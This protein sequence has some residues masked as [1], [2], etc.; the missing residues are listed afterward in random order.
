MEQIKKG[1]FELFKETFYFSED[2]KE[3]KDEELS[4]WIKEKQFIF[5]KREIEWDQK[6]LIPSKRGEH[7]ITFERNIGSEKIVQEKYKKICGTAVGP[8]KLQ[9]MVLRVFLEEKEKRWVDETICLTE[10]QLGIYRVE[11]IS[12]SED[13]SA[14]S[15]NH[16]EMTKPVNS[17]A[18]AFLEK[19]KW[20]TRTDLPQYFCEGSDDEWLQMRES[21]VFQHFAEINS[22]LLKLSE[23]LREGGDVNTELY[24]RINDE[25]EGMGDYHICNM[26]LNKTE[27]LDLSFQVL[28]PFFSL[29]TFCGWNKILP[30]L[31]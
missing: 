18:V 24:L 23:K 30:F 3:I 2:L 12:L 9:L 6:R 21:V 1:N 31:N 5:P 20:I 7:I 22:H 4:C 16:L 26:H 19:L 10:R 14:A 25:N 28:T 27:L 11:N 29:S 13:F 17:K 15:S 8:K